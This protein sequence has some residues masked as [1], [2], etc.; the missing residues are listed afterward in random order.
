MHSLTGWVWLGGFLLFEG[1][2]LPPQHSLCSLLCSPSRGR[3]GFASS[4]IE[5]H[6]L[7]N[8]YKTYTQTSRS[9]L[10]TRSFERGRLSASTSGSC[11]TSYEGRML[12]R[13]TAAT[14]L[15][16][17]PKQGIRCPLGWVSTRDHSKGVTTLPPRLGQRKRKHLLGR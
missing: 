4:Q 15:R 8:L 5:L 2:T 9:L 10:K 3:T 17:S 1:S 6:D 11:C 12:L 14:Q 16:I 7:A 13:Q